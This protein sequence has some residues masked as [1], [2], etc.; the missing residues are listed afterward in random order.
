MEEFI[1]DM[2]KDMN[3][4]IDDV[5]EDLKGLAP[6]YRAVEQA[7]GFRDLVMILVHYGYREEEI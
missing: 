3:K 5:L 4:A 7:A 6:E 1:N 2:I